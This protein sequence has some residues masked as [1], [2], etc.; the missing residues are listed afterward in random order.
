MFKIALNPRKPYNYAFFCPVSKL[1]LTVSNPVGF[2]HEVTPAIFKGL[3][4][5]TLVDVD[6]VIDLSTGKAKEAAQEPIVPPQSEPVAPPEPPQN[7]GDEENTGK[8]KRGR[9]AAQQPAEEEV[10]N[11]L[12]EGITETE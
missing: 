2:A 4:G 8:K 9:K 11:D 7:Q 6:G 1:H 12:F 5:G 10:P 3:K